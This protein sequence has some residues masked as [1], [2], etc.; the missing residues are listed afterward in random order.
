MRVVDGVVCRPGKLK[1]AVSGRFSRGKFY[2]IFDVHFVR[3][4]ARSGRVLGV[5]GV[6]NIYFPEYY[7]GKR[8]RF[9]V[10]VVK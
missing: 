9:H 7:I 5:V 1:R 10:E 8:V 2:D 4:C 6:C 3:A